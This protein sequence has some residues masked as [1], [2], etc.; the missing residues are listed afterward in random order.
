[1]KNLCQ[2]FIGRLL[3]VREE[4]LERYIF[5][6]IEVEDIEKVLATKEPIM[7]KKMNLETLDMVVDAVFCPPNPALPSTSSAA[8]D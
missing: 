5:E 2:L 4:A 6:F 7:R 3:I 1:M 8:T